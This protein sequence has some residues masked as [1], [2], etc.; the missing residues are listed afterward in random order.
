[1]NE[2]AD[3][4][5]LDPL[6]VRLANFAEVSPADGRPWSANGLREAYEEGARRYGW[7]TRTSGRAGRWLAY[8]EAAS[9]IGA[10]ALASPVPPGWTRPSPPRCTTRWGCACAT[11][12][13]CPGRSWSANRARLSEPGQ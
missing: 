10:R 12:R 5:G 11:C 3:A 8:D 9:L 1:M 2:L 13:S 7:R 4:A 6:D